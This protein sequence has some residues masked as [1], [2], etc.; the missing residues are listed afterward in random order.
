M[1]NVTRKFRRENAAFMQAPD[2]NQTAL[3]RAK[4][5]AEQEIQ[6]QNELLAKMNFSVQYLGIAEHARNPESTKAVH[7]FVAEF[8]KYSAQRISSSRSER[9]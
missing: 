8:Y 2:P 3:E 5:E 6:F 1:S 4:V 7:D 9:R